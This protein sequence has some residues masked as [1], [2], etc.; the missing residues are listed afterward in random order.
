MNRIAVY[1][2]LIAIGLILFILCLSTWNTK[3]GELFGGILL[4]YSGT[5]IL[6]R[7]IPKKENTMYGLRFRGILAGIMGIVVGLVII[8]SHLT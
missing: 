6:I 4:L 7:R 5:I 8:F 3:E 2:F 1:F